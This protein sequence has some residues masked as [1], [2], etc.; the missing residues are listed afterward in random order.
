MR[1]GTLWNKGNDFRH[2]SLP[3]T[4]GSAPR[5]DA[6][7]YILKLSLAEFSCLLLRTSD[8]RSCHG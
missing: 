4:V 1:T 3:G 7:L 6:D 2:I 8:V 5:R